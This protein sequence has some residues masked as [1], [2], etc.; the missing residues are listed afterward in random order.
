MKAFSPIVLR[1]SSTQDYD[2]SKN[3]CKESIPSQL[4]LQKKSSFPPLPLTLRQH[5]GAPH[6]DFSVWVNEAIEYM[7]D[8]LRCVVAHLE[9]LLFSSGKYYPD[10]DTIKR[11]PTFPLERERERESRSRIS[12]IHT[13]HTYVFYSLGIDSL[14]PPEGEVG[15][16]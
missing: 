6:S 9:S 11:R 16:A 12:Y 15:C 8:F 13:V 4:F 7:R 10:I 1:S 2:K 5:D 14:V 3:R